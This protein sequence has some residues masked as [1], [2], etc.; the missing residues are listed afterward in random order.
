MDDMCA[1][2]VKVTSAT[3]ILKD[4]Y[5][6]SYHDYRQYIVNNYKNVHKKKNFLM[7]MQNLDGAVK[8]NKKKSES[9]Y[10]ELFD[11]P[12]YRRANIREFYYPKYYIE[13]DGNLYLRDVIIPLNGN[14]WGAHKYIFTIVSNYQPCRKD[15]TP[16]P[17]TEI[18]MPVVVGDLIMTITYRIIMKNKCIKMYIYGIW[19][20]IKDKCV[21]LN[22]TRLSEIADSDMPNKDDFCAKVR[23]YCKLPHIDIDNVKLY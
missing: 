8:Y 14:N 5:V 13:L 2:R 11:A 23:D 15:Y 17:A 16:T 9:Y 21:A 22:T 20:T 6:P 1:I 19:L 4:F 10:I 3:T 18:Y 12:K 7:R